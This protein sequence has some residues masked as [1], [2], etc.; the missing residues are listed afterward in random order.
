MGGTF[1]GSARRAGL[2][3]LMVFGAAALGFVGCGDATSAKKVGGGGEAA[4]DARKAGATPRV[5]YVTNGIA[6]FWVIA[7]KGAVDAGKEFNAKVEVRMPP[8]G[9]ID[10]QRMVQEL[11]AGG[12][13]G[14]AVSPIDPANQGDLLNEIAANTRLITHDSDAPASKRLCY[15]GMDNYEAGRMVGRLVKESL[16]DGGGIMLFVGRLGQENARLRRQGCIDEVLGRAPDRTRYDE[17]G[18]ELTEGKYTIL[19]TRTDQFDFAKA[20]ALPQDAITRYPNL[21]CMVGLF[22]Y[23]PPKCLEAVREAGKAKKIKIVGFD[24]DAETLQGIIDGDVHGTVVQNPY[25]YGYA[26]VKMLAALARGE[27]AG[28]PEGKIIDI[29]AQAITKAN[30]EPFRAQLRKLTGD[31]P[32]SAEATEAKAVPKAEAEA[33]PAAVKKD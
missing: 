25:Q 19:D 31:A 27:D 18:K 12:V 9:V 13:D 17:P 28:I 3:G 23:N 20:K 7:A 14:M 2:F 5:A 16:P 26:S 10:Q 1:R 15:I 22:A 8:N 30:V 21:A 11:L 32:K 33:E 6:S 29:P 4:G 24:E